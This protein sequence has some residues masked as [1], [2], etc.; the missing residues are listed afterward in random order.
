MIEHSAELK[1]LAAALAKAQAKVKG[2]AKD[3]TNPHFRSKYADLESVWSACRGPLT[4]NGLSVSQWPGRDAD[5][6]TLTTLLLHS[7]G[8]WIK[9]TASTALS[10]NDAQ[11]VGSALT[12][13]RRYALAAVASVAPEDD[14]GNAAS[15]ERSEA[16]ASGATTP[17][18][19]K[20]HTA[21]SVSATVPVSLSTLVT[22]GKHK[23][24]AVKDVGPDYFEWIMGEARKAN[25]LE[26]AAALFA[27]AALHAL[28]PDM[29]AFKQP[30]LAVQDDADDL[31]F[32]AQLVKSGK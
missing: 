23:G 21:P 31:A 24:K 30:P 13:L 11:G 7:S 15:Q 5:G 4:E 18:P 26:T 2:A 9:G 10:K 8:Q 29:E 27:K 17:P 1:D 16:Q 32:D 12:Y 6:C 25:Q 28:M 3:S 20:G 14:D 22:W 19:P